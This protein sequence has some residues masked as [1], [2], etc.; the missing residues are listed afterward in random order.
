VWTTWGQWREHH[1][2][3]LVLSENTGF[4]RNYDDDPYG[5]YNPVG[6]YY[7]SNSTL[8]PRFNRDRSF[9]PKRVFL[10]VRTS[11]GAAAFQ[12]NALAERGTMTGKLGG[13]SV[14]AVHD[15][16]FG[17][18]YV[19][20]NPEDRSVTFRDG[21]AELDGTSYAPDALPLE[22]VYAFDAMWFA[23]HGFYPDTNVYA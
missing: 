21:T 8:F 14:V 22:R 11:E 16:R 18:G 7:D 10:G 4:A 23:W 9:H 20:H 15:P 19:Y 6:G 2:D 1:P 17:T 13:E 12:E 5:T 3:T